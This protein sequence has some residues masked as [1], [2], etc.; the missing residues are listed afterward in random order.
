MDEEHI[1][2]DLLNAAARL[3]F[4]NKAANRLRRTYGVLSDVAAKARY[5]GFQA[6]LHAGQQVGQF[7]QYLTE[8]AQAVTEDDQAD[9]AQI[10]MEA[11]WGNPQ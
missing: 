8:A 6:G 5:E 3:L 11:L 10:T 1:N 2:E 7:R 9:A 4:G